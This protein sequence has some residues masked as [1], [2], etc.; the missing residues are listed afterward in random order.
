MNQ[1]H[2]VDNIR[3]PLMT[4]R[5]AQICFRFLLGVVSVGSVCLAET[6]L[7]PVATEA[8]TRSYQLE[9]D[10]LSLSGITPVK[11]HNVKA[12]GMTLD[13]G[14]DAYLAYPA[15]LISQRRASIEFDLTLNADLH[16]SGPMAWFEIFDDGSD[17]QTHKLVFGY[18]DVYKAIWFI[19]F[20]GKYKNQI[21]YY[22]ENW[23]AGQ[24][25]HLRIE[26]GPEGH[27][28]IDNGQVKASSK[29]FIWEFECGPVLYLGAN[30][31]AYPDRDVQYGDLYGSLANIKITSTFSNE[32]VLDALPSWA[33]GTIDLKANV[34]DFDNRG[35]LARIEICC[36]PLKIQRNVELNGEYVHRLSLPARDVPVGTY[37]IHV[38][39][40]DKQGQN[41]SESTLALERRPKPAWYGNKIGMDGDVLSPWTPVKWDDGTMRCVLRDYV[42]GDS[43]LPEQITSESIDILTGPIRIEG[44]CDGESFDTTAGRLDVRKVDN[45]TITGTWEKTLSGGVNMTSAMTFEFDGM[46]WNKVC[47]TTDKPV[48]VQNLRLIIPIRADVAKYCAPNPFDLKVIQADGT[49]LED[50]VK[51]FVIEGDWAGRWRPFYTLYDE[52]R[53]ISFFAESNQGW[54]VSDPTRAVEILRQNGKVCLVVHLLDGPVTL[55]VP[56]SF[57]FGLQALPVKPYM[58]DY[59]DIRLNFNSD[60]NW[61]NSPAADKFVASGGTHRHWHETWMMRGYGVMEPPA[62]IDLKAMFRQAHAKG[63]KIIL[64]S[65]AGFADWAQDWPDFHD[66]WKRIP[67]EFWSYQFYKGKAYAVSAASSWQDYVVYWADKLAREYNAD[68]LFMDGTIGVAA[69]TN[70]LHDTG[71]YDPEIESRR[72]TWPILRTRLLAKRI[73][74]VFK[75]ADPDSLLYF[76]NSRTIQ[77]PVMGFADICL[78]GEENNVHLPNSSWRLTPQMYRLNYLGLPFGLPFDYCLNAEVPYIDAIELMDICVLHNQSAPLNGNLNPPYWAMM[79][80]VDTNAFEPYWRKVAESQPALPPMPNALPSTTP[81]ALVSVWPIKNGQGILLAIY[82]PSDEARDIAV[83]VSARGTFDTFTDAMDAGSKVQSSVPSACTVRVPARKSRYIFAR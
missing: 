32:M 56:R 73:Y 53:G 49:V 23:P 74:R 27:R 44:T 52:G 18:S 75:T 7:P 71:W 2:N 82:N 41:I 76:H 83:D 17:P 30:N 37:P 35:R 12:H 40:Y 69:D 70:A 5:T 39:L 29:N 79:D 63:L 51:R 61:V 25:H 58:Q 19:L 64:Y 81:E 59:W 21:H 42:F 34:L 1:P 57:A 54:Q 28:I 24:T 78:G 50:V 72:P 3:T 4:S 60:P 6:P 36:E 9:P 20:D 68:G 47:M 13:F 11:S 15:S 77:P 16:K 66:Q 45:E 46:L 8:V 67:E 65:G 80:K 43:M 38:S 14:K 33:K 22:P 55:D 10:T 26:W 62:G 31:N 48:T